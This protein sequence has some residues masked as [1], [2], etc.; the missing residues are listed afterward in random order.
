VASPCFV[1]NGDGSGGFLY[2]V[3]YYKGELLYFWFSLIFAPDNRFS[4]DMD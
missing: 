4:T 1:K 3:A 2:F